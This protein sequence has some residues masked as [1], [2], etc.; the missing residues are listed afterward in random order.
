MFM[1]GKRVYD[2]IVLVVNEYDQIIAHYYV[3][4]KSHDELKPLLKALKKR[5]E[6]LGF[7]LPLVM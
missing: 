5:Y 1:A 3:Y 7:D 2:A 6:K 4:S